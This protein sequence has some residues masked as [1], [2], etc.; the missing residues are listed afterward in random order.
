[1]YLSSVYRKETFLKQSC[2]PGLR[3]AIPVSLYTKRI[4]KLV[5][6]CPVTVFHSCPKL[7]LISSFNHHSSVTLLQPLFTSHLSW[8][9]LVALLVKNL[10][11]NPGDPGL[12]PGLGRAPGEGNGSPLQ[13]YC[14]EN[15]TDSGAGQA[16]IHGIPKSWI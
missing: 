1:M 15:S 3:N 4:L 5:V 7:C 2:G 10:I 13:Y 8:T 12:I 16:T 6:S 14:L 9:S 11:Y